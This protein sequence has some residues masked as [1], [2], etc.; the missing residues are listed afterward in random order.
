MH[1]RPWEEI[2]FYLVCALS[3]LRLHSHWNLKMG[4]RNTNMRRVKYRS[5][6]G[7]VV[8]MSPLGNGFSVSV[9][10]ATIECWLSFFFFF[11]FSFS[12]FERRFGRG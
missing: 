5:L 3:V 6:F 4:F 11:S 1:S 7:V 12:V 8:A 2:T 10:A 9:G